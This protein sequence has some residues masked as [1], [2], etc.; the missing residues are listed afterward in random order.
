MLEVYYESHINA[1]IFFIRNNQLLFPDKL[2]PVVFP[3]ILKEN[4]VDQ[5]T[6]AM[7]VPRSRF[8]RHGLRT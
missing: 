7:V 8:D 2:D 5:V 4:T 1:S 6:P 3:P